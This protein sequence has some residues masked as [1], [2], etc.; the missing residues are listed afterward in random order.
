M[1][2]CLNELCKLLWCPVLESGLGWGVTRGFAT[3]VA[4]DKD[5]ECEASAGRQGRHGREWGIGVGGGRR[6]RL[7]LPRDVSEGMEVRAVLFR[8]VN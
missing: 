7:A 4:S 6:E 8:C 1:F 3:V 2:R 5:V